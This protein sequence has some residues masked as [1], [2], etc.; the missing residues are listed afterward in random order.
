MDVEILSRMQFAVTIFYHF[1][2]VPLTL[3][4]VVLV[5]AMEIQHA[6]TLNPKYKRM[7]D[8]WGKLFTINFVLGVVTG[9]TMEFQFGTNWG[10][11]SKFMGDIFGIPLAIEALV[12]FF[13][14]S[15]F[16]G[17]WLFG[18]DKLSP[19]MRAF[20]MI[21]VALGTTMSGLWIITAD[22][23]MQ[24]PV[25]YEIV[26]GRAEIVDVVAL[27]TNPYTWHMFAHTITTAWI[28][29]SFFVLAIS[30]YHLLKKREVDFFKTSFKFGIIF[31]IIAT[32]ITPFIGHQSG[33]NAAKH[34][35]SKAAAM[36]AV[37]ETTDALPFS[38]ISIPIPSEE[39]NFELIQIPKVGSFLY[40]NDFNGEVIGLKDIPADERPNV[41]MVFY[42]FRLM[43]MLG[44]LFVLLSWFGYYL[45]RKDKLLTT[46][47]YL[48]TMLYVLPL[49]WI[50]INAGWV[51]TEVGR[52]PWVVYGLMK[53][54]DGISA[55][56]SSQV[57]FSFVGLVIFYTI[58]IIADV[59]LMVKHAKKG[60]APLEVPT[61]EGGSSH[62]S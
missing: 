10:G 21:M 60:P 58:L 30:A 44:M 54:T 43:V 36:E 6:R 37:W 16:M 50:A 45:H 51:V 22:G 17:V 32:T 61:T 14:E 2:F 20:S 19:K 57:I 25:G 27:L 7:A 13:L 53:T 48:R 46:P 38:V 47:W 29:G 18:R 56:A 11:Y 42:A 55:I 15:V 23:F 49:P 62:V 35:P 34:Q 52:Q 33:N 3:G 4:L 24:N 31:A 39:R 9:L 5:A 26:N 8:F 41:N 28:A 40:T 1:L 12:A 59:Y